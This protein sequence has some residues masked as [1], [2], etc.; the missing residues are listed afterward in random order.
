MFSILKWGGSVFTQWRRLPTF[1]SRVLAP[2]QPLTF[3]CT[4]FAESLGHE[5]L[6]FVSTSP[7]NPKDLG[8]VKCTGIQNKNFAR[9]VK[10]DIDV[11][12]RP[13]YRPF[14]GILR[15]KLYRQN[16][17]DEVGRTAPMLYVVLMLASLRAGQI[18]TSHV[19]TL[20][21]KLLYV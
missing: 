2:Y 4:I 10:R 6:Q 21:S 17:D 9:F 8:R 5:L 3:R 14:L 15:L 1:L 20:G 16:D 18:P 12:K 13:P 19:R 7:K 11:M